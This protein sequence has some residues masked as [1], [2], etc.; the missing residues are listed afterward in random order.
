MSFL[1]GIICMILIYSFNEGAFA[2]ISDIF[3]ILYGILLISFANIYTENKNY[4]LL[5]I[6]V[7]LLIIPIYTRRYY[8]I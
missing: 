5:F 4:Y 2:I 8:F 3:T 6:Y 7:I 1:D